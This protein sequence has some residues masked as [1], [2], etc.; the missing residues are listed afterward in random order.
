METQT[1]D[2]CQGSSSK[3]SK[4]S[5]PENESAS[6][7]SNSSMDSFCSIASSP[8]NI[9]ANDSR[10][11][12]NISELVG[13]SKK[14]AFSLWTLLHAKVCFQSFFHDRWFRLF[15]RMRYS[16]SPDGRSDCR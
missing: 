5:N 11:S 10:K 12:N 15:T 6:A 3:G 13:K 1:D 16:R 2:E 8:N 14:A 4:D 9:R 7:A